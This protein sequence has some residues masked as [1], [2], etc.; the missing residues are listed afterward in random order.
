MTFVVGDS[1]RLTCP[2]ADVFLDAVAR[3]DAPLS[4]QTSACNSP[5]R[6]ALTLWISSRPR[7]PSAA[8]STV[9]V[10]AIGLAPRVG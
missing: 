10:A 2:D 8:I 3:R 5:I 9:S 6:W 4:A 1:L 7:P